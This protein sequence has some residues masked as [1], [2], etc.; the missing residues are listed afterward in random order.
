MVVSDE[1][2]FGEISQH[3]CQALPIMN[4]NHPSPMEFSLKFL[5]FIQRWFH[6]ADGFNAVICGHWYKAIIL[7]TFAGQIL[8]NAIQSATLMPSSQS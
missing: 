2:I 4:D 5:K 8:P 1:A 3:L 6:D 7:V